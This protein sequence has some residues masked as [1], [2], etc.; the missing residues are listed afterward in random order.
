MKPR[1]THVV[2]AQTVVEIF[3][4]DDTQAIGGRISAKRNLPPAIKPGATLASGIDSGERAR[5]MGIRLLTANG[6][7]LFRSIESATLITL[8]GRQS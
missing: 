7:S 4:C 3:L 8:H 6:M 2:P 5:A 1:W